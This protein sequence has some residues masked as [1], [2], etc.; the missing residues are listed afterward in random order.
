MA[1]QLRR[2]TWRNAPWRRAA[3]DVPLRTKIAVRFRN[4]CQPCSA[5]PPAKARAP[6]RPGDKTAFKEKITKSELQF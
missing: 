5:R 6:A 2:L 3:V 4:S 1:A